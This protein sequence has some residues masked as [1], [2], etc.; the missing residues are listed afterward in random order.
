MEFFIVLMLSKLG[1]SRLKAKGILLV[2]G[3]C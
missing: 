3:K 1:S 2:E